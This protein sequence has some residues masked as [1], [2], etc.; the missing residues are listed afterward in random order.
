[1]MMAHE[2]AAI[3]VMAGDACRAA[4]G[5]RVHFDGIWMHAANGRCRQGRIRAILVGIRVMRFHQAMIS[6]TKRDRN[7][8]LEG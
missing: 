5:G 4:N 2:V 8:L 1:M 7:H 6:V 3:G